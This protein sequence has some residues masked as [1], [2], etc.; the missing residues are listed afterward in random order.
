MHWAIQNFYP[1]A[2]Y[3]IEKGED[4]NRLDSNQRSPLDLA[5]EKNYPRVFKALVENQADVNFVSVEI[6]PLLVYAINRYKHTEDGYAS[7]L[8]EKG[9]NV[10]CTSIWN[11]TPLQAAA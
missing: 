6:G 2:L 8:I 10:N 9:A 11:Q 7:L 5:L 4:T 3:F 1:A